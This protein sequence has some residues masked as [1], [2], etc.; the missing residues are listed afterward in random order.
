MVANGRTE[1]A[2]TKIAF[3]HTHFVSS[4]DGKLIQI[5]RWVADDNVNYAIESIRE[6]RRIALCVRRVQLVE[7]RTIIN[8][9]RSVGCFYSP[10]ESRGY[11]R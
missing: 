6:E 10:A 8:M 3:R 4:I 9:E 1:S 2:V 5:R 7:L 11:R